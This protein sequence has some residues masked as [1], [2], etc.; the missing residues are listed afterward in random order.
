MEEDPVSEREEDLPSDAETISSFG[1][2]DVQTSLPTDAC[3]EH[4]C[5]DQLEVL[6]PKLRHRSK[7]ISQAVLEEKGSEKRREFQ[8][9]VLRNWMEGTKSITHR[10]HRFHDVPLCRM[11]AAKLLHMGK[12]KVTQYTKLIEQGQ[13]AAPLDGRMSRP[14]VPHTKTRGEE[15]E[16]VA[17]AQV[18]WSW[19]HR[20]IAEPLAESGCPKSVSITVKE[21]LSLDHVTQEANFQA[22]PRHVHPNVTLTELLPSKL[23]LRFF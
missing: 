23:A 6:H 2:G 3:C 5:L 4:E 21:L 1:D 7:E 8:F 15:H 14:G 16:S 11:A 17:N 20:F 22:D 10:R 19:V 12:G 9:Q 13:V 18:M